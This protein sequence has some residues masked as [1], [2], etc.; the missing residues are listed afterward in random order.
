M[1]ALLLLLASGTYEVRVFQP[2][3][4]AIVAVKPF[5]PTCGVAAVPSLPSEMINPTRVLFTDVDGKPCEMPA[6]A[7]FLAALPKSGNGTIYEGAVF[8]CDES[9]CRE[10]TRS[11]FCV[12][13][14]TQYATA[15]TCEIATRP[16]NNA[17]YWLFCTVLRLCK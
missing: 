15:T 4:S 7:E 8:Y 17:L 6:A 1:I 14:P 11:K 12:G 3:Q 16:N 2:D 10:S 9:G 13:V 5:A